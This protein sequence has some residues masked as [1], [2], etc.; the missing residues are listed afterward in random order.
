MTGKRLLLVLL[1]VASL[2]CAGCELVT[3]EPKRNV[4]FVGVGLSYKLSSGTAGSGVLI[5]VGTESGTVL[6]SCLNDVANV[7]ARFSTR[8]YD[9]FT[10]YSGDSSLTY[11]TDANGTIDSYSLCV[12]ALDSVASTA[13]DSDLTIFYYSGHGYG[14]GSLALTDGTTRTV[15]GN[16]YVMGKLLGI[17]TLLA[18]LSAIAGDKL[19]VMDSCYSGS[20]AEEWADHS[21]EGLERF[22]ASHGSSNIYVLTASA[23]DEKS[24]CNS[25]YGFF[26]HTVT[27]LL[28]DNSRIAFSDLYAAV[29]EYFA[30]QIFEEY[31]ILHEMHPTSNTS[32][33]LDLLV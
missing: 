22:F 2:L 26:T 5:P 28:A 13:K 23:A 27:S 12:S 7:Y 6:P 4:H 8:G 18:K 11:I 29:S 30:D 16:T 17:D 15:P 20:L 3:E 24:F 14:D 25:E 10:S 32:V 33:P 1:C 19:V 31:G 9:S 21:S